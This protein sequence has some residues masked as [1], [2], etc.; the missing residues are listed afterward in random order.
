M[1]VTTGLA[2]LGAVR[3]VIDLGEK[4]YRYGSA[5]L[6]QSHPVPFGTLQKKS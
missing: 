2:N 5:L 3:T 6:K 4:A 1:D